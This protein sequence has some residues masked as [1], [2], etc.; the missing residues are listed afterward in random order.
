MAIRILCNHQ[1]YVNKH[2]AVSHLKN[3]VKERQARYFSAVDARHLVLWQV[4]I[5]TSIPDTFK[6]LTTATAIK[7]ISI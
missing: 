2:T 7:H 6:H 4:E 5:P 1:P 3:L